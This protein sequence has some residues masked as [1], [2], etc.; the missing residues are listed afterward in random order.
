MAFQQEVPAEMIAAMCRRAFG[1]ATTVIRATKIG[2]GTWNDT[3]RVEIADRGPVIL[4]VAPSPER[5]EREAMR[6]EYAAAPYFA[7]LGPLV[8]RTLYAD[9]T[10]QLIGRDYMLQEPLPGVPAADRLNAYPDLTPYFRQLGTITRTIHNV[11]GVRFGPVAAATFATW[12]EALADQFQTLAD[13]YD[14]AGLDAGEVRRIRAAVDTHRAVLDEVRE[15][16]LLHGDLWRLNILIDP[17]AP[18]PAIVGILDYDG[19][20]WGDPLADW[21]IH[22]VLRREGTEAFWETYGPRPAEPI[23]QL[24]YQARCLAG[25]RLDIYRRNI[26]LATVPPVHWD[27]TDVLK[28]LDA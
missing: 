4:R 11:R 7:A 27:L 18:E 14:R 8:P 1:A 23:R 21:T 19:A 12:S 3:Y 22:Q 25:A 10:H 16:R 2:V 17:D 24:F 6:N 13:A 20:S 28:G 9:F 26:D 5:D 15:P